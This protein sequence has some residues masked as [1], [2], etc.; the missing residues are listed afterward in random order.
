VARR[1]IAAIVA[2]AGLLSV[3]ACTSNPVQAPAVKPSRTATTAP[4]VAPS[5]GPTPTPSPT[6]TGPTTIPVTQ[7]CDEL[8][9]L[10][11]LYDYNPNWA[12]VP[13]YAPAPGSDGA[14]IQSYSGVACGWM[15]LSSNAT[16][17]IAVAHLSPADID[18]LANN[19][20]LTTPSV[21]TYGGVD[22]FQSKNGT[23]TANVFSG[24]YWIVARSVD[25]FE[26]GDPAKLIESVKAALG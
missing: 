8:V 9:S 14:L 26:P 4:V 6:A 2:V 23:G 16:M 1:A 25:F 15:N 21:P 19:L 7:T 12:P 3:A 20:V 18:K 11:T 13:D 10:Q 5:E 17:E 24:D 22:Y